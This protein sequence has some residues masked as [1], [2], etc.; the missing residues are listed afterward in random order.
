MVGSPHHYRVKKLLE[1][2][3]EWPADLKPGAVIETL[4]PEQRLIL[5]DLTPADLDVRVDSIP[6][7]RRQ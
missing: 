7:L 4:T 2:G 1:T 5:A 6:F 3:G